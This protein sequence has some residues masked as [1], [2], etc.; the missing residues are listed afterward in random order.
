M[1]VTYCNCTE[2][3]HSDTPE[4]KK[5]L[6]LFKVETSQSQVLKRPTLFKQIQIIFHHNLG[7]TFLQILRVDKTKAEQIT[8]LDVIQ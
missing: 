5:I 2:H 6:L 3:N 1:F 4:N 8:V 7:I